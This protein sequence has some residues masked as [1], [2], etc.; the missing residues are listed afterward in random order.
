MEYKLSSSCNHVCLQKDVEC[1]SG[2]EFG[3][4]CKGDK[5]LIPGAGDVC[6]EKSVCEHADLD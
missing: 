3:C 2:R 1:S 4:F 5:V 6:Y